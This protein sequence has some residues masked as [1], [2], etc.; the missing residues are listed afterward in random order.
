[1]K[2]AHGRVV[3]WGLGLFDW[4]LAVLWCPEKFGLASP[5]V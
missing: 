2:G 4:R 5:R 1:M 3:V